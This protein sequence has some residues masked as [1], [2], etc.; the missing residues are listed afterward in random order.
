MSHLIHKY[1]DTLARELSFDRS[2][3]R[4][5]CEEVEDHLRQSAERHTA[6][7]PIEAERHAIELFGPAKAIA[8]QFVATSLLK[9]SRAVGPVVVLIVF[10]VFAAMEAR[11]AWYAATGW[12]ASKPSGFQDIGVITYSFDRYA[13]YLALIAGLCAWAY[14]SRM[15][16]GALDKTRLQRSFMLS[17]AAVAALIG[18][19]LADIVLT[20]LRLSGVGWSISHLLPIASVGIEVALVVVLVARIHAVTSLVVTATLQFDL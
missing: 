13:F 7:G 5:V 20:A 17:S 14:A 3:S 9:R 6:R 16:S 19:V 8:A 11:L 18:S 10:G 2:L 12:T 4:R 1:I 15:P